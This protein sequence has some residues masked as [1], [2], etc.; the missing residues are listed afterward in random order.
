MFD[1]LAIKVIY[2]PVHEEL[3]YE[4]S[5]NIEYSFAA[6]RLGYY[7]QRDQVLIINFA[8]PIFELSLTEFN[9]LSNAT[10]L[11]KITIR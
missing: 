8:N 3:E 2:A 4:R 11:K 9:N 6:Q 1:K 10:I 7:F 5:G